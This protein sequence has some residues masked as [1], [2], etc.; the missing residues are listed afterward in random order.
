MSQIHLWA[1][2]YQKVRNQK[3]SKN[4]KRKKE[5]KIQRIK[6]K[7]RLLRAILQL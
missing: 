7:V 1:I 4:L 3:I 5:Q 6:R 2:R